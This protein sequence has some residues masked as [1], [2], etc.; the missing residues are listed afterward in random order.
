MSATVRTDPVTHGCKGRWVCGMVGGARL[1]RP[2]GFSEQLPLLCWHNATST[3]LMPTKHPLTLW[4]S[5]TLL[6]LLFSSLL[7]STSSFLGH[8]ESAV[9]FAGAMCVGAF[10]EVSRAVPSSR[11][12]SP[13]PCAKLPMPH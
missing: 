1:A 12:G 11:K 6:P 13:T 3:P 7:D 4:P 2:E 5:P 8:E 10:S 9:R